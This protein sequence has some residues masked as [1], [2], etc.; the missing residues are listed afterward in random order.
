MKQHYVPRVYLKNFASRIDGDDGFVNVFD[1]KLNRHKEINIKN[2]CAEKHLYTLPKSTD[3]ATDIFAIEKLY[4]DLIEP[5]YHK[6]Y[7]IL[8]NNN[9][10]FI[11]DF[12]RGEILT[13]I[14]H[15]YMRNPRFIKKSADY[16]TSEISKLYQEAL[17]KNAKGLSYLDED[18]SF[19]E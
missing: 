2:I 17:T 10:S 12:Q 16:H 9:I 8:T 13:G 18:F 19:K 4:S 3:V 7:D 6:A 15:L 1:K 14:F 11:N 5:M